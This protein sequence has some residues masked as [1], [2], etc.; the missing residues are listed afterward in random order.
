MAQFRPGKLRHVFLA[1][2]DR[3]V[4]AQLDKFVSISATHIYADGKSYLP[5]RKNLCCG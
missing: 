1:T 2:G 4:N 3:V 5:S